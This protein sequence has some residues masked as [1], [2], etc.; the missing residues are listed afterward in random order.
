MPN[1][2]VIGSSNT[3]MVVKTNRFP[4][5]GETIIGGEFL[6]NPGGKGA[7]QAVAARRAGGE[8]TLVCK[9]G[10]DIFG[11][12]A[13]E[14]FRKEGIITD[15][16]STDLQHPSG[17]ALILVDGE[18][19]NEIVVAPGSNANLTP[20]DILRA[21]DAINRS[22]VALLQLEIPM[23]SVL[24]AARLCAAKGCKVIMNP[25]PAREL[26]DEIFPLLFLVTPNETEAEMLTGVSVTDADSAARAARGLLDK[27]VQNVIITMGSSGAFFMN[28][29][30]LLMIP[31]PEVKVLDTTAAGDVFNGVLAVQLADNR[32]WEVAISIACKAA[33]IS[34]TRMGAQSS[35]PF[36]H[37]L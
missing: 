24:S 6:M 17:V 27:G 32:D 29:S 37:E 9:V 5:P 11:A 23:E 34:V 4:H 21:E 33:S 31:S 30:K 36:L 14:G 8:V 26:P 2:I 10:N 28:N 7:N 22:A 20:A 18:G 3:D 19:E 35:A 12:Q 1:V 25:A 13:A 15:Y 16:I